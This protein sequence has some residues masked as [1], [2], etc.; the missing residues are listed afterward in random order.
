[1]KGFAV[2]YLWGVFL[3]RIPFVVGFLV[4]PQQLGSEGA[5]D[6]WKLAL[7]DGY[8]LTLFRGESVMI[9]SVF[10]KQLI[11]LKTKE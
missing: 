8:V 5:S 11:D 2:F 6:L 9:H 10:E 1:M 7:Q 3:L 4:C